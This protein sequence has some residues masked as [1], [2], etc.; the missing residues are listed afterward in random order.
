VLR[1]PMW[2]A[3]VA[4][5]ALDEQFYIDTVPVHRLGL[6]SEVGK[7]VVFLSS[8]DAAYITGSVH[9]IDGALTAIP[10]G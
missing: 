7:L 2:D 3:D 9:T 5:G 4:R 1:T 8:D 6:P 10:A